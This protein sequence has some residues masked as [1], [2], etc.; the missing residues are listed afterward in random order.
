MSLIIKE[1]SSTDE[2]KKFIQFPN[3]LYKGS[4]FYI[5]A[6]IKKELYTL[7][8]SKNP[9][10]DFCEAKYW[11]AYQNDEIVG[12]IAAI[13]ND[14]YNEKHQTKYLRFGWFDSVNNENVASEL[15]LVVEKWAEEMKADMI[16]GPLGF[17][18]F[19]AAGV[20]VEGFDEMPTSFAHYNFPYYDDLI[21]NIGFEKDVDWIEYNIK[22][23]EVIPEKIIKASSLIKDRYKLRNA[24]I[25]SKADL[26]KYSGELFA[27]L[28]NTYSDLY[29]FTELSKKQIE[30]LSNSFISFLN[31]EFV[32]IIL[33]KSDELIAFGIS[34]PSLAKSLKKSNG[35]LF[36][37]GFLRVW[38]ALRK[39]DTVDLL[40]IAIK[41]EYQNKG[42]HSLI[43]DKIGQTF[44]KRGIKFLETTRELENNNKIKRLWDDYDFR[45]HK[46]SRC[47]IKKLN[48]QEH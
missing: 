4:K 27:L 2:L 6:L 14:K 30:D 18:S 12:R 48:N 42:V 17:T 36:P 20:L 31:P 24:E 11:L 16:H 23:P 8:K 29:G 22:V 9:A 37:F 43:F 44:S 26:K 35:S 3:M 1:I 46:R 33:N 38:Q 41:P 7:E 45:Q 25:Y 19:D 47:Y 13:V 10:F 21:K 39:N 40:L 5:P 32:S 15:F 34:I 28:N